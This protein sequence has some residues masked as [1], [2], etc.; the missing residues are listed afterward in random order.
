MADR[1]SHVW[2]V[3][4][5]LVLAAVTSWRQAFSRTIECFCPA[6]FTSNHVRAV[7]AMCWGYHATWSM[8]WKF[9]MSVLN[10][11][12][13]FDVDRFCNVVG[14][15]GV[16]VLKLLSANSSELL[17]QD[18]VLNMWTIQNREPNIQVPKSSSGLENI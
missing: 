10:I 1:L 15:D 5:L 14:E 9:P 2:T 3:G 18:V 7:E 4:L 8:L 11:Y 13:P 6:E 16:M 17:V 12:S